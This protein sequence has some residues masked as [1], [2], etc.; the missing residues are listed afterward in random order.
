MRGYLCLSPSKSE[1]SFIKGEA[2]YYAP[3][4]G[5]FGVALDSVFYSYED[6]YGSSERIKELLDKGRKNG[7]YSEKNYVNKVPYGTVVYVDSWFEEDALAVVKLCVITDIGKTIGVRSKWAVLQW[8]WDYDKDDEDRD[9]REFTDWLDLEDQAVIN[10]LKLSYRPEVLKD[11]EKLVYKVKDV[12]DEYD[13]EEKPTWKKTT[14]TASV[15]KDDKEYDK[16]LEKGRGYVI[17]DADLDE[18]V[19]DWEKNFS[20][21]LGSALGYYTLKVL[22]KQ[23][24]VEGIASLYV[25]GKQA[26]NE[27][28]KETGID[29]IKQF[30]NKAVEVNIVREEQRGKL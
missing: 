10:G 28:V 9:Y 20:Y 2:G 3:Q 11:P 12:K 4:V 30:L 21:R 19:Q 23:G 24:S 13:K 27:I 1:A 15:A 22:Q 14:V 8:D 16:E 26:F 29:L 18:L 5:T 17:V 7:L 6:L 25:E